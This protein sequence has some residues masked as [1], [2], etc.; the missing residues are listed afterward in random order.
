MKDFITYVLPNKKKFQKVNVNRVELNF[1]ESKV[2]EYFNV[3]NLTEVRDRF[4]GATFLNNFLEKALPIFVLEK[5]L[6]ISIIDWDNIDIK[7]IK[8]YILIGDKKVNLIFFKDELPLINETNQNPIIFFQSNDFKEISICGYADID[9]LETY[10][11][12]I[13]EYGIGSKLKKMTSFYGFEK[14]KIFSKLDELKSF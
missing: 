13:K 7:K 3:K 14:L 9:V 5:Y 1:L 12:N 11:K 8:D 10:Q 4:E 2:V 6:K